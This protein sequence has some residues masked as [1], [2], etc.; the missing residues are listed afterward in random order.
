MG[1]ADIIAGKAS[2]VENVVRVKAAAGNFSGETNFSVITA[3]GCFYYFDTVY[4]TQP[5]QLAIEISDD[6]TFA[7]IEELAGETPVVVEKIMRGI[8]TANRSEIRH[9]GSRKYGIQALL[10]GIYIHGNILYFHTQVK[11][12]SNVA[13]DIDFFRFKIVDK[14]VVK[15][16]AIQEAVLTPVRSH[17]E[18]MTVKGK[19]TG[20]HVFAFS[21]FTIPDDKV[22]II[23]IYER[24]GSRH[25]SFVVENSDLIGA[26]TINT[27][28][29][30]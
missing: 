3:D 1:S 2:G 30:Q 14:K 24:G 29:L 16:T 7:Q 12:L 5:S 22:L 23:E 25:Q 8:H 26:L 9:I 21:K 17:N 4:S 18:A 27:L 6:Q 10:K 19:D 11:N 20:R 13:Y 28:N 15:R